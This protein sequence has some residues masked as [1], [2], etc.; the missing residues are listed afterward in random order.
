MGDLNKPLTGGRSLNESGRAVLDESGETFIV[1]TQTSHFSRTDPQ[2]NPRNAGRGPLP[3]PLFLD[4][5]E[6]AWPG[7]Q[8]RWGALPGSPQELESRHLSHT[9]TVAAW[10]EKSLRVKLPCSFTAHTDG[11]AGRRWQ[12]QARRTM[13]INKQTQDSN[14]NL[15]STTPHGLWRTLV[16]TK[17]PA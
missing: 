11:R 17:V 2:Q 5:H 3:P 10:M 13:G 7:C 16:G 15:H 14:P 12:K 9:R 1:P 4:S 6:W 8:A